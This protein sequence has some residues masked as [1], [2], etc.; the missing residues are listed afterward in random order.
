MTI[1]HKQRY[2]FAASSFAR[3]LGVNKL[4]PEIIAFCKTWAETE[5]QAPLQGLHEV[6][7]YFKQ[8]WDTSHT[9]Y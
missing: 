2:H 9:Q 1:Q 7:R 5:D 4:T 6:D 8:L 3:M